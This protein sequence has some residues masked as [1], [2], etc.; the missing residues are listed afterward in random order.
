MAVTQ[1]D[2]LFEDIHHTEEAE[3]QR[4]IEDGLRYACMYLR[5]SDMMQSAQPCMLGAWHGD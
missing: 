5:R 3:V 1:E 4:G 2:D